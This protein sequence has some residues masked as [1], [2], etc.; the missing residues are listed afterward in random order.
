MASDNFLMSPVSGTGDG[1]VGVSPVGRN[2]DTQDYNAIIN[3]TSGN[4]GQIVTISQ[5]YMPY[6]VQENAT[7]PAS[8]G[9]ITFT[10][11]TEYDIV[12]QSIPSWV[13]VS[14]GATTYSDGQR[15]SAST[16]SGATFTITAS[17]NT[18]TSGRSVASSFKMGIYIGDT[19]QSDCQYFSVSQA[20][21]TVQP[22]II[23]SPTAIT[24]NYPANSTGSFSVLLN[25]LTR[26]NAVSSNP[27]LFSVYPTTVRNNRTVTVTALEQNDN[28]SDYTGTITLYTGATS[29]TVQVTQYYMPYFSQQGSTQVP[30]SGG[31]LPFT[32]HSHY[33]FCFQ[34]IPS[35]I[36]ITDSQSNTY[37]QGTRYSSSLTVNTFYL[38]VAANTTQ[39]QREATTFNMGHYIN[40]TLQEATEYFSVTQD[41]YV[42]PVYPTYVVDYSI[43]FTDFP[44]GDEAGIT[45]SIISHMTD[46]ASTYYMSSGGGDEQEQGSVSAQTNSGDGIEISV[47]V[48]SITASASQLEVEITYGQDTQSDYLYEGESVSLNTTFTPNQP[49]YIHIWEA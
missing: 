43:T 37:S 21:R 14:S 4:R 16:A 13:T 31:T 41:A 17:Q 8:G 24:I 33:D 39:V 38:V 42:P 35:W 30:A 22:E 44:S 32:I 47:V 10:A 45:V 28:G 49:I 46:S 19:I 27:S 11:Y 29:G 26:A 34:N 12:F 3:F 23:P 5:K 40:T 48:D 25:D 9:S 20:G 36:T 1:T 18:S 15:I 6:F 7:I 2:D